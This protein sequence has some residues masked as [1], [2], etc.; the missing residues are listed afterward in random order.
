MVQNSLVV[1]TPHLA[2]LLLKVMNYTLKKGYSLWYVNIPPSH[3]RL[4]RRE[5][6]P[7]FCLSKAA[8]ECTE[9]ALAEITPC[10][11]ALCYTHCPKQ[12]QAPGRCGPCYGPQV[13]SVAEPGLAFSL[14]PSSI[15]IPVPHGWR[16]KDPATQEAIRR[17]IYMQGS[18]TVE[19]AS[20]LEAG[21]PAPS[22]SCPSPQQDS[23]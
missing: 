10:R 14:T 20:V 1:T 3:L 9:H 19:R 17:G 4:L 16:G 7:V 6:P 11:L 15:P 21:V 13:E 2:S 12:T 22:G 8:S 18:H 5:C 23:A